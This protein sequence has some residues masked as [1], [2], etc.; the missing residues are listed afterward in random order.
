M[1]QF[2]SVVIP[3]RN[4]AATIRK[5]LEAAL[6]SRYQPFEVVVVDDGSEDGS[7]AIIQEFPCRLLRLEKHSGA[8]TA[9]N[10]GARESRGDLLFFTDA[11]CLL[12]E[13]TLALAGKRLAG[14]GPD[15][16]LGGTYTAVPDDRRFFSAF[17]SA[18]I[19]YSETRQAE[20]P[21]YLATHAM[22]ID[23]RR[24]RE[25][26]GFAENYLPVL[27][28]VE[29]SHRLRRSGYTLVLDPELQVR[30]I[31]NYS[32]LGSLRNALRKSRYWTIYSL[33]HGDLLADS[34]AASTELKINVGAFVLSALLLLLALLTGR[35]FPL[36]LLP[37]IVVLNLVANRGVI[38]ALYRGMGPLPAAVATLYYVLV[39][40]LPVAAGAVVGALAYLANP[41]RPPSAC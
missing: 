2:I 1:A 18:L 26:H 24:F 32:F 19:N 16:V 29:F 31:F 10:L 21:D 40:P 4:G 37:G 17:Q 15:L 25:S 23:A 13:E 35:S 6:A 39:Y 33:G 22:A 3:N 34:G 20:H 30:H 8:S 27:E 9:R 11:D 7:I 12:Q 5:C 36:V 38:R 14:A 28:D 41:R